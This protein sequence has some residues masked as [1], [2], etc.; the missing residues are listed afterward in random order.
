MRPPSGIMMGQS[1][2]MIPTR[3]SPGMSAAVKTATTPGAARARVGVDAGDLGP[4]VVGEAR[5]RRA[6][7]RE[8]ACRRCSRGRPER[9]GSASYLVP[10]LADSAR[11][12]GFRRLLRRPPS[13]WR[14]GSSRTRCSGRGGRRGGGPCPRRVERGALLV[15]LGL[16]PHDDARD[17]EAALEPAARSESSRRSAGARLRRRLRGS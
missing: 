14:R 4:G 11:P 1:R 10:R 3:S 5:G 15:D 9:R 6:A 7:A 16:G 13:R 12:R 2:W 8:A 17:A